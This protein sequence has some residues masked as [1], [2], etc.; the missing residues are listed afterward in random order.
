MKTTG[1]A[2]VILT[3]LAGGPA[4]ADKKLDDAVAKAEDQLQKGKP[5]EALKTIQKLAGTQTAEAQLAV[6]RFLERFGNYEEAAAALAKGQELAASAPASLQA[7]IRAT[8]AEQA[9]ARGPAKTALGHAQEAVKLEATPEHLALLAR[10]QARAYDVA[11]AV[12][13][14]DKAVQAGAANAL[15]HEARGEAMLALGRGDRGLEQQPL[16]RRH[17]PGPAGRVPR[18]Q[19][20]AGAGGGG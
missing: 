1:A 9:L 3:L 13:S 16:E 14:A 5:E 8:L 4:L 15:A 19:E 6:G 17:R 18:S 12:Q 10:A 20:P 2:A 11:G 7:Q